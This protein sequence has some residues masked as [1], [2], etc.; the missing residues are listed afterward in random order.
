M[1]NSFFDRKLLINIVLT[2]IGC[3]LLLYCIKIAIA[4]H[5]PYLVATVLATILGFLE[6]RKGWFLAVVQATTIW[7]V[8][9]FFLE[10]P[11]NSFNI[12]LE[13]FGLYGS[14]ILTFVGSFIGGRLK[15]ILDRSSS[16][17]SKS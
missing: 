12:E 3:A 6:P 4:A 11:T 15:R 8:Y 9:Q 14:M 2:L 5:L 13:N 17:R 16:G 7:V 10:H 1:V